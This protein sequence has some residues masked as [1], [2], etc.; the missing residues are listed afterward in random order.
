MSL[1]LTSANF[2]LAL[3]LFCASFYLA[4][5]VSAATN[6]FYSTWYDVLKIDIAISKYAPNNKY[7][8]RGFEHLPKSEHVS[9]FSGITKAI[10]KGGDGLRDLN[11][12]NS[13]SNEQVKLLTEAEVV[14]LQDVANFTGVF[15]YLGIF[16]AL[17]SA[18]IFLLMRFAKIPIAKFKNLLLGG[19]G[20]VLLITLLVV[21]VGPT[22]IFYAGHEL[23]FPDN[24]QWFFYYEDSLM[25]TM[26]KA[27][28]LFGPIVG[29]LLLLTLIVWVM[30][31][32]LCG[33]LMSTS[34]MK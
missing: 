26:M 9:L 14:H 20:L 33:K 30:I 25:S 16:G 17:M 12:K 23:I 28:A 3:S 29:Q 6:F 2:V 27:P 10:Q 11:F 24:H 19:I 5:Q 15:K 31:L 13:N 34:A 1:K 18:I 22:K 7:K 4:W 21:V 8:K 32:W